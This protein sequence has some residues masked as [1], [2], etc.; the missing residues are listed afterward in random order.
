MSDKPSIAFILQRGM[1]VNYSSFMSMFS[2][3]R[4]LT[5]SQSTVCVKSGVLGS[6]GILGNLKFTEPAT[7]VI[8]IH[9]EF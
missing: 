4:G 8:L 5:V 1:S 9:I 7:L 3:S 6:M 2:S